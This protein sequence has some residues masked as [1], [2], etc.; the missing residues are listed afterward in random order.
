MKIESIKKILI[1]GAGTMGQQI[2]Y[3]CALHG[4]D[5]VIYDISDEMLKTAERYIRKSTKTMGLYS[6][7]SPE[8]FE[9][10]PDRISY[11]SNPE[12]AAR[13]VDLVN[14]SVPED[15]SLKGKIFSQFNALCHPDTIFTTNTS[16]LVPS[17]FAQATGRPEKLCALH[18]HV[19]N[20][21]KIVDVMPHPGTSEETFQ[22]VVEFAKRIGQI[23][24]TLKT[25]HYGYVY[26]NM[27]MSLMDSALSIAS[28]GVASIED[29]D[30]SWMGVMNTHLG[31]FGIMDSIG[32]LTC[33]KV[34]D[35]W[36]NMKNDKK[37]IANAAFIKQYVDQGKLGIKTG[38][39][40]YTYPD[41][42]YARPDFIGS[43]G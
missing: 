7:F 2:G 23:P 14:E 24:I 12:E 30:R 15:P 33:F 42:A 4:Y 6:T 25:E 35:F 31:P 16:S 13:G 11:T 19:V 1:L 39:G 22:T 26:N 41:P 20:M 28:R 37:A 34:T 8:E 10:A 36:A 32:L 18:F 9:A 17:M 29:I 40:F 38:E 21:T 5:V 3:V 27:L 43:M